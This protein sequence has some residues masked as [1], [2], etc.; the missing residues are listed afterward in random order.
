MIGIPPELA[1]IQLDLS[2][3]GPNGGRP[4]RLD[5]R[6]ASYSRI[7]I[8]YTL[9]VGFAISPKT[10]VG[11]RVVSLGLRICVDEHTIDCPPTKRDSIVADCQRIRDQLNA[12]AGISRQAVE[13]LTGRLA[14]LS[15]IEP[16]LL[17]VLHVGYA[18]S[19]VAWAG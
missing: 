14:N 17:Q 2:C 19:A 1:H 6:I 5:S 8:L 11:D 3:M 16:A 4:A 7:D 18:I 12:P 13:R 9:R 15:Q 10:Q